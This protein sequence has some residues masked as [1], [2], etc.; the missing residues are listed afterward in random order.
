MQKPITQK[1][2]RNER[3]YGGIAT[4]VNNGNFIFLYDFHQIY[5][6]KV[7]FKQY[8]LYIIVVN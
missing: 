2:I 6:T 4:I 8:S 1:N 3:P 5:S 7:I